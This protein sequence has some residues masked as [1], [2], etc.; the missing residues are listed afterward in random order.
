[1]DFLN[2]V[3]F[4][5]SIQN[6]LTALGILLGVYLILILIKRIINNRLINRVKSSKTEVDN[7]IIPVLDQTRW[8]SFLA[9]GLYLG[10]LASSTG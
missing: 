8:F 4:E 1:M 3:I 7:L 6:W 5:N 2:Y 9:L 10:I